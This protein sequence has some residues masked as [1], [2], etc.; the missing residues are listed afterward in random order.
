MFDLILIICNMRTCGSCVNVSRFHSILECVCMCV[1]NWHL[2][3][4][5]V[6]FLFFQTP[7]RSRGVDWTFPHLQPCQ[8]RLL[9]TWLLSE[10]HPDDNPVTK[11]VASGSLHWTCAGISKLHGFRFIQWFGVYP[12]CLTW[13]VCNFRRLPFPRWSPYFLNPHRLSNFQTS[14]WKRITVVLE[15]QFFLGLFPSISWRSA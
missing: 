13:N 4:H 12:L 14:N 8:K 6:A 7:L 2:R 11:S 10:R 15:Q 5:L 9:M 3:I 1:H